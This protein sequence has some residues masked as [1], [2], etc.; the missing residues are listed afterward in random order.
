LP[1][2]DIFILP[3]TYNFKLPL[4]RVTDQT[5]ICDDFKAVYRAENRVLVE[6]VLAVLVDK[7]QKIYSKVIRSLASNPYIFTFYDFSK[8]I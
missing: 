4:T 2:T 7:W 8:P 3:L 1:K 6:K 5:E